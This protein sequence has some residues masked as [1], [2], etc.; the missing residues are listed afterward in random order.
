MDN[1]I[2]AGNV[3][4]LE[5]FLEDE[6]K[7]ENRALVKTWLIGCGLALFLTLY[8]WNLVAIPFDKIVLNPENLSAYVV[9]QIDH[10]I[11][12]RLAT[13]E[14]QLVSMAPELAERS[15]GNIRMLLPHISE[16]GVQHVD[17][18]VNTIQSLDRVTAS[19][20]E[21]FFAEYSDQIRAYVSKYGRE[22]FV[23]R[24]TD[25]ILDS[26]FTQAEIE[27]GLSED[28]DI[29]SVQFL[30][31]VGDELYRLSKKNSFNMSP[32]ERMQRRLITSWA[33]F[34]S[35]AAETGP[36]VDTSSRLQIMAKMA[37]IK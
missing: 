8:M 21:E 7:K 1:S 32:S 24:F 29:T 15:S 36:L 11:P 35:E 16:Y 18:L 23:E 31:H 6:F 28:L 2:E 14:E 4:V 27:L 20:T 3:Q 30:N 37:P 26:V 13:L 34:I 5:K 25:Q 9:G 33:S 12:K 19:A 10:Q 17:V 22:N